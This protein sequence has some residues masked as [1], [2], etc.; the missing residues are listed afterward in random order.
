MDR[1]EWVSTDNGVTRHTGCSSWRGSGVESK[2]DDYPQSGFL[3][4]NS[5]EAVIDHAKE[6]MGLKSISFDGPTAMQIDVPR[7]SLQLVR[8]FELMKDAK[9]RTLRE[10]ADLTG[11]LETSASAR[12]RD[13]RKPKFG[14]HT[15][16]A[17]RADCPGLVY[18]YRV[19]I[20]REK[21][22]DEQRDAA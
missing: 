5:D 19:L 17:R 21:L 9:Y 22:A 8:V 4:S 1:G 12:L 18:E 15:V 6:V 13:L 2:A 20:N 7:L 14:G 16:E 10:V 11:C 3:F